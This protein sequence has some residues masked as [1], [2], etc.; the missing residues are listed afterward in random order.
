MIQIYSFLLS[1]LL[2]LTV[3]PGATTQ[4][5]PATEQMEKGPAPISGEKEQAKP[6]NTQTSPLRFELAG[7][8][9]LFEARGDDLPSIGL[10]FSL[11]LHYFIHPR[12]SLGIQ[13]AGSDVDLSANIF[14]SRERI[15]IS[16]YGRLMNL[17]PTGV[18]CPLT[19]LISS[20]LPS[21]LL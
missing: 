7:H 11:A 5:T 8:L 2:A 4:T 15:T 6:N 1:W 3:T 10:G 14:K 13:I 9:G 21:L 16:V 19:F 20:W 17:V 18:T 12:I